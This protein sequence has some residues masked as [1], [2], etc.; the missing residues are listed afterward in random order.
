MTRYGQVV[1]GPPGA[2]KTTY[3]HGIQQ[4]MQAMGRECAV[5]NLDF[6]N[7]HV[8]GRELET[9][10]ALP[11][12][13]S[14]YDCVLD[15]RSL[16]SLEKVMEEYELG[17]NGGMMYCME[18]LLEHVDW[19]LKSIEAMPNVYILF[20]CP[21]QVEL[22]SHHTAMQD[23]LATLTKELDFRLC[24]VH[25]ID[26]FY[27]I[28]PATFISAVLLVASTMLRLSLPHVNVLTK[29]DLLPSYGPLP[30]TMNFYTELLNLKPLVR[31]IN[32]PIASV[33]DIEKEEKE[34][35]QRNK[36]KEQEDGDDLSS[37]G[38]SIASDDDIN[39]YPLH[40]HASS[41][42]SGPGSV[43]RGRLSRMSW[44]ICDVLG[45]F[46]LV[47]FIPMNVQDATTVGRVVIA[48]DKANGYTFAANEALEERK[49]QQ[50]QADGAG[51]AESHEAKLS[52][53][54]SLASQDLESE[55]EKSLEIY[56]KYNN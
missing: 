22:F 24:S 12:Q 46:G 40:Q 9:D 42:T 44:E 53:L 43:L 11:S 31:Y 21:G 37:Y 17:P 5:V 23:I 19:L 14:G 3:C 54:F 35:W 45:D 13:R 39:P 2:G 51:I 4:F 50:A 48:V 20:D 15:V 49:R 30:F 8:R 34:E 27:C 7:E 10:A 36:G 29:I 16:V 38:G 55:Y 28:E 52:S 6:A 18:Y 1:V 47:N 32:N 33:E 56:E 26:S 41:P 25:L